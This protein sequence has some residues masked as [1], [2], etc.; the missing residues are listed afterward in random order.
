[1]K[2]YLSYFKLRFISGLQYRFAA[3]TGVATQFFFGIVIIMVYLAFYESGDANT[4]MSLTELISYLWL[5]QIF[6][7]LLTLEYKDREI[8]E[9]I[10]KG[11]IFMEFKE[12]LKRY[13]LTSVSSPEISIIRNYIDWLISLPWKKSTKDN[14][15]IEDIHEQ[16]TVVKKINKVEKDEEYDKNYIIEKFNLNGMYYEDLEDMCMERNIKIPLIPTKN[17]LIKLIV[18]FYL[19]N[20]DY[21]EIE[22]YEDM[23]YDDL[24]DLCEVRGIKLPKYPTTKK[25]IYLLDK[26]DKEEEKYEK[27]KKESEKEYVN[28][29]DI[30]Y[31]SEEDCLKEKELL[32]KKYNQRIL[33]GE[34]IQKDTQKE[35]A[36]EVSKIMDNK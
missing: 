24:L 19:S 1:M 32:E 9:M 16:K 14:N 11:V 3:V 28:C 35:I 25:L 15:D 10:K 22:Y 23:S 18:N 21:K 7:S 36:E 31:Q 4:P 6:Y 33:E 30:S 5:N 8:I 12:E 20:P 29:F 2:F 26:L 13:E 17:K 34:K 27:L